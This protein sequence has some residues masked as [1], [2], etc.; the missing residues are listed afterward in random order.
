M[1]VLI[2][3]ARNEPCSFNAAMEGRV[4]RVLVSGFCC[5]VPCI[6]DTGGELEVMRQPIRRLK[7][8]VE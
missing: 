6:D 8:G 4:G 5:R 7:A 1:Q 2:V 3:F